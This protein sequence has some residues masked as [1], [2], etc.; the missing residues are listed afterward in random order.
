MKHYEIEASVIRAKNGNREEL[1]KILRQFKPF[2]F[3][4][5]HSFNIRNHDIYDLSQIGYVALINAVA[6][7]RI[8]STTFSSY[9]YN[10][11]K[12]EFRYK[13]RGNSK[14][15]K[16]LSLNAPIDPY[17]NI[18]TEFIDCIES[19]ENFEEDLIRTEKIN[20]VRRCISKLPADELELVIMVYYSKLPFKTYA[21]KKGL[22]YQQASRK[23][24]RI[25]EK[26]SNYLK[27]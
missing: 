20:E 26:L 4:T 15:D 2:I 19:I 11:I 24:E 25:L 9:A 13:A 12:N 7:Y 27:R 21:E 5:A 1:L 10:A 16:E 8:G 6:K 17:G 3:K 22:T 14:Y 23:R 18:D